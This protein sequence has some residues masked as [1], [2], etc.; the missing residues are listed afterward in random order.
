MV[1]FRIASMFICMLLAVVLFAATDA[2][3]RSEAAGQALADRFATI[4]TNKDGKVSPE[5]FF[6]AYPHMKEAAFAAIDTSKDGFISLD[7]WQAFFKSH[8]R[9]DSQDHSHGAGIDAPACCPPEGVAGSG[10][11][12]SRGKVPALILPPALTR[13]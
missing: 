3:A 4:D 6:A 2:R 13:P 12:G 9:D 8:G 7:E 1:F 10:T 5:E 11:G